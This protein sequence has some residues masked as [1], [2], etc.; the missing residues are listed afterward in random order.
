MA[1]RKRVTPI[2]VEQWLKFAAK[3]DTLGYLQCRPM[4]ATYR[5]MLEHA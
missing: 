4:R 3:P 5:I 2:S 1:G